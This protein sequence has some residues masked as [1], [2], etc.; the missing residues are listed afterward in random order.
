MDRRKMLWA[1]VA[2]LPVLVGMVLAATR[3]NGR[4]NPAP[5]ACCEPDCCPPGCCEEDS[6]EAGAQGNSDCCRPGCC[7]NRSAT[8]KG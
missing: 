7:T 6:N 1:L 4:A 2:G 3:G 8:T 5:A